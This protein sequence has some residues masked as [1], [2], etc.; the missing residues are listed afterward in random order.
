MSSWRST[1]TSWLSRGTRSC[2]ATEPKSATSTSA[3]RRRVWRTEDITCCLM[4]SS[5]VCVCSPVYFPFLISAM[6]VF[7]MGNVRWFALFLQAFHSRVL[8]GL[9]CG[10]DSAA[11]AAAPP[12]LHQ[13]VP[14]I[15][16]RGA[17]VYCLLSSGLQV[18]VNWSA[19]YYF[20][21]YQVSCCFSTQGDSLC[22]PLYRHKNDSFSVVIY[23]YARMHHHHTY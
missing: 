20:T 17:L 15:K 9:Q 1:L 18:L 6:S 7:W 5:G 4:S 13:S 3:W 8:P 10:G 11:L 16:Q 22:S 14:H 19:R 12:T 2:W 21:R 23:F